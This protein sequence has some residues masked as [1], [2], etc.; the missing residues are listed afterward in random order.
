[1]KW[2]YRAYQLLIALPLGLLATVMAALITIMGCFL[3]GARVWGY[4][5]GRYWS[6]CIVRLL[7]LPVEVKGRDKLVQGQ[8]YIFVANHQGA[9]DIFL[10][11]GFL[12]RNFKWMMKHTLR[13][14]PFVGAACAAAKHIFIDRSSKKSIISSYQSARRELHDGMS[15]VV[16]PEG[17]RTRNGR[18]QGFKRGAFILADELAL[19]V[20][21]LT[22]EGS[23]DVMPR[24]KDGRWVRWH[25]LKLTIHDPID[26]AMVGDEDNV[27]RLMQASK[28]VIARQLGENI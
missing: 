12:G 20:V 15:L 3:G 24:Q 9:F 6:R 17:S 13:K 19:P 23:Y 5:P 7:L 8:S 21:P 18:L 11:Y 4:Y 25:P 26:A 22:I 2:L 1:M 16:F 28:A 14:L 27:R 10:I